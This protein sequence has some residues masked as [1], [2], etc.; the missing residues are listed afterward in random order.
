MSQTNVD[1]NFVNDDGNTILASCI[2]N[3]TEHALYVLDK[4]GE[5]MHKNVRKP[6][7]VVAAE[8]R[9]YQVVSKILQLN[10][11]E[12]EEERLEAINRALLVVAQDEA[13]DNKEDDDMDNNDSYNC[14]VELISDHE[15]GVDINKKDNENGDTVLTALIKNDDVKLAHYVLNHAEIVDVPVDVD[16]DA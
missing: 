4:F 16:K 9:N 14:F 5:K 11:Y 7:L 13:K 10:L 12:K 3:K 6:H 15:K 1:I 2:Q 8:K